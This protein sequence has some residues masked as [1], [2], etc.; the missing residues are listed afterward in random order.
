MKILP[1]SCYKVVCTALSKNFELA[2]RLVYSLIEHMQSLEEITSMVAHLEEMKH[3][4]KM[5]EFIRDIRKIK[6][7]WPWTIDAKGSDD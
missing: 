6:R 2:K 1:R 7:V 3:Y 5:D 4:D